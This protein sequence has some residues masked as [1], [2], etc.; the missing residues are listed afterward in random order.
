[1][2]LA[3]E[4]PFRDAELAGAVRVEASLANLL[5]DREAQRPCA[6]MV[7]GVRHDRIVLSGDVLPRLQ[8]RHIE[9]KGEPV[10]REVLRAL[11]HARRAACS[12]EPHRL[13]PSLLRH[14]TLK[15]GHA[16]AEV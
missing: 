4:W 6:A 14:S 12:K 15:T 9:G 5:D 10:H 11:Q 2:D 7:G 3:P 16:T 8:F 13:S 1:M